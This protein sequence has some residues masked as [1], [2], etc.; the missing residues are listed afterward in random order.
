[1]LAPIASSSAPSDYGPERGTEFAAEAGREYKIAIDGVAG[2]DGQPWMG[3]FS[4]SGYEKVY[5]QGPGYDPGGNPLGG[6]PPRSASAQKSPSAAPEL[7]PPPPTFRGRSIDAPGR[8]V[9][10]RFADHADGVHYRC[11]LDAGRFRHCGSP[12]TLRGLTPGKHVFKVI[13]HLSGGS[14]SEPAVARFRVPATRHH[15]AGA[16]AR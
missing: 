8:R 10:F 1:M 2:P 6:N 3:T 15:R 13:A 11:K 7:T 9:T 16:P 12:M 4:V 5:R 14:S